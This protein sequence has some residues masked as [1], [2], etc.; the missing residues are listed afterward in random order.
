VQEVA[1]GLGDH[2]IVFR[3][4]S[5]EKDFSLLQRVHTGF[6]AHP[7]SSSEV[8]DVLSSGGKAARREADHTPASSAEVKNE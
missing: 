1:Y 4:S 2:A 6:G 8:P 3:F 7:A 5:G